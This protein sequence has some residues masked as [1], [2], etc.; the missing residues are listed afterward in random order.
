MINKIKATLSEKILF[1]FLICLSL[2]AL[3]SYILIK[4]KCFFVE[5][6]NLK[7]INLKDPANVA[8][9][10]IECGNV[11]IELYPEISPKAVERF[12]TL[13]QNGSYDG[14]AFYK[15]IKNTLIQV[16][17]L[18]FG[19]I[20]NLDYAK[21]GTGKSGLGL[22]K[23]ELSDEFEFSSGTVAFARKDLLDT[24]DSEFFII[25]KEIPLYQ[26][27]YTPIGKVLYGLDALKKVKTGNKSNY[28]LR[29]D[30]I[31]YFK[32]LD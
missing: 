2:T 7:K 6:L 14:S 10:N 25:S 30:Y 16:G 28:V 17:D 32:L 4:D 5:D 31:K 26:G 15:V 11:V 22:L 29:P 21:I 12:K 13:I 1:V 19:N 23:S 9:M 18:Q 3:G 27:E 24:E 20:N 8:I